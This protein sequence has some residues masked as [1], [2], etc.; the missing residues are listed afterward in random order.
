MFGY[1][2]RVRFPNPPTPRIPRH[3][4][5]PGS[6]R[7][8]GRRR[9]PPTQPPGQSAVGRWRWPPSGEQDA[10]DRAGA[11][12]GLQSPLS[13]TGTTGCR[14]ASATTR[15]QHDQRLEP[16][17]S[18]GQGRAGDRGLARHRSDDRRGI[19]AGGRDC[20]H[21]VPKGTRL[22]PGGRRA[23]GGGSLSCIA[24]GYR[25]GRRPGEAG[26]GARRAHRPAGRPGEQRRRGVGRRLCGF[27][28]K[29]V[30]QGARAERH[31]TVFSHT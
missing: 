30:P 24:C 8:D 27:P 10:A 3:R 20:L 17:R 13:H 4:H 16:V 14:R 9:I 2:P 5:R 11:P 26:R 15:R 19:S 6:V 25:A 28:G 23:V 21:L 1:R 29:R 22:R 18:D 7:T 12:S 31:G